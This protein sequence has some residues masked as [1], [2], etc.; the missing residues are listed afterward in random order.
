[1]SNETKE[2]LLSDADF[3]AITIRANCE[4]CN[5]GRFWGGTCALCDGTGKR[6]P[7]LYEVRDRLRKMFTKVERARQQ[8][9]DRID[10][11]AGQL[12]NARRLLAISSTVLNSL[13]TESALIDDIR[14]F[15]LSTT[16]NT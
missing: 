2:P 1:M 16:P 14:S 11:L 3:V 5:D 13:K 12:K 10:E 7:D 15:L 6:E 4:I 9:K 8:D